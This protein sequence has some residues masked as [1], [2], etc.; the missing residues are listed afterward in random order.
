M[1]INIQTR[2]RCTTLCRSGV[3]IGIKVL[4]ADSI[5]LGS[6]T[7]WQMFPIS[8]RNWISWELFCNKIF[9]TGQFFDRQLYSRPGVKKS[10][11]DQFENF[12][13]SEKSCLIGKIRNNFLLPRTNESAPKNFMSIQTPYFQRV[14]QTEKKSGKE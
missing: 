4:G 6:R 9:K 7:L 11:L 14:G 12:W 5:L 2:I 10:K 8:S 1:K 3:W 13:L